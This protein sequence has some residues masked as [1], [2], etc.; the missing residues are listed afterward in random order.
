M[1]DP[2]SADVSPTSRV[3]VSGIKPSGEPHL[4]NLAGMMLPALRM[5]RE[6]E[7]YLFVADLHA[8]TT[9]HRPEALRRH[10]RDVAAAILA[11]GLDPERTV[12]FRQS[13][14]PEVLELTWI[15]ACLAPVGML[16]RAHA[17]KAARSEDRSPSLGLFSYP[18]LMAADVLAFRG[19]TVPVGPDQEQHVEIARDLARRFNRA[20]GDTFPLPRPEFATE[21]S[22]SLPG[23]DGRK[24]SKQY[25]NTIPLAAT[26]AERR[27][28][29]RK[30]VT[31]SS[32]AGAPKDPAGAPV[33]ELYRHV[34]SPAE[35]EAL[36]ARLRA[37]DADWLEAKNALADVLE[38]EVGPVQ[39]RFTELRRDEAALDALLAE[40]A[41]RA[42]RRAGET[43]ATVRHRTGV[44]APH[45]PSSPPTNR[46]DRDDALDEA[47]RM[48]FPASDP[49]ALRSSRPTR[50]ADSESTD[51]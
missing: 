17:Y 41:G 47:L 36:E 22:S 33:V 3:L 19:D 16:E 48:T 7:S 10:V 42:R 32:P 1:H 27:R 49:I 35:V 5:A 50:R 6:M 26:D 15:L 23:L 9:V 12:L 30:I 8:L 21:E 51:R 11:A 18:V 37:G 39:R 20:F 31:D 34:A 40:G 38:R 4:G 28:L 13:D 43:L 24:M 25:G 2:D 14:V 45:P 46:P 29:V 44:G